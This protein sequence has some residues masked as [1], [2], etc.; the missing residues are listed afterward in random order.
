M[1]G[2]P[3]PAILDFSAHSVGT[4]VWYDHEFS[5]FSI[6]LFRVT[7]DDPTTDEKEVIFIGGEDNGEVNGQ[8]LTRLAISWQTSISRTAPAAVPEPRSLLM[9]SLA[10]LLVDVRRFRRS[11]RHWPK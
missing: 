11:I 2:A 7:G 4:D 5:A 6:P 8:D 1:D 3:D 9:L 10:I